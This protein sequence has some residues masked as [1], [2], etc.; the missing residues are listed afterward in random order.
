MVH[1]LL[2]RTVM[3]LYSVLMLHTMHAMPCYNAI[4]ILL[5]TERTIKQGLKS[6][7]WIQFLQFVM[8]KLEL[9]YSTNRM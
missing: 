8:T 1:T 6:F 4:N 7:G 2:N 5:M 3:A 9:K